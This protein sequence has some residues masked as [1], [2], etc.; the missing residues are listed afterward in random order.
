LSLLKPAV[1]LPTFLKNVPQRRRYRHQIAPASFPD[2]L[3]AQSLSVMN[4]YVVAT[5]ECGC[6]RR[7]E[8]EQ[9]QELGHL[10][11][12]PINF[13]RETR[14]VE[15]TSHESC[16]AEQLKM[17]GTAHPTNERH[18]QISRQLWRFS[19]QSLKDDQE[20]QDADYISPISRSWDRQT[21]HDCFRELPTMIQS[22]RRISHLQ[23]FVGIQ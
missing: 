16:G 1:F 8:G 22:L 20:Q 13:K 12:M 14:V 7:K 3:P 18:D 19:S 15:W 9:A 10:P 23:A 11:A 21:S 4:V 2:T 5:S 17:H 6:E